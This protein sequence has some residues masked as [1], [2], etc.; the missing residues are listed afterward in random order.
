M[1]FINHATPLCSAFSRLPNTERRNYFPTLWSGPSL[2]L[3]LYFGPLSLLLQRHWLCVSGAQLAC[4]HQQSFAQMFPYTWNGL[5]QSFQFW[6]SMSW[7]PH[8]QCFRAMP[9]TILGG[10]VKNWYSLF[11]RQEINMIEDTKM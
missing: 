3:W 2:P 7:G 8:P 10:T 5:F 6:K 11:K 1:I 9:A 4:S